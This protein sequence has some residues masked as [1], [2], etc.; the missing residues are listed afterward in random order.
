MFL[1]GGIMAKKMCALCGENLATTKDHIPPRGLYPKPRPNGI[2]LHTVPA[3][4]GC[5]NDAQ[6]EDEEF[7]VFIGFSTGEFRGNRDQVI[8][9]IA[10]TIGANRRIAHQIFSSKHNIYAQRQSRILEPAVAI[11]FNADNYCKVIKRIIRAL[12]W[13]QTGNYLGKDTEIN[14]FP[15]QGMKL[16]FAKS[17]KELMDCLEPHKLNGDTFAYKV[18]FSDDGTSVWGMQFF[19]KH[20]VFGYAEA[21]K[22]NNRLQPTPYSVR[23]APAFRRA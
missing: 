1:N 19:R 11:T 4:T 15:H 12:Y 17:M 14:I 13:R 16:S 7:K 22:H 10:K 6:K 18:H 5:N 8:D 3:C 21:P 23:S 9:W 2:N 20:T